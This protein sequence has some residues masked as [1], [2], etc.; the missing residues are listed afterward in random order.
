MQGIQRYHYERLKGYL[1]LLQKEAE[2]YQLP[3]NHQLSI[4][5]Q[6]QKLEKIFT[7]YHEALAVVEFLIKQYESEYHAVRKLMYI[8]KQYRKTQ[9]KNSALQSLSDLIGGTDQKNIF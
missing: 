2:F 7:N 1:N 6:G 8:H 9:P 3:E 5:E 4:I